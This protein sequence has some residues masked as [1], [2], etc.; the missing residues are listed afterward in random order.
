MC[1]PVTMTALAISAATTAGSSFMQNKAAEQRSNAQLQ[2]QRGFQQDLDQQRNAAAAQ[3]QNN[4]QTVQQPQMQQTQQEAAS[5]REQVLAPSYDQR[6]LLP[7]QG[8]ASAAVRT[9]VVQDQ[10]RAIE[11][12]KGRA[13]SQA[14]LEAFG[15]AELRR[16]IALKQ[17]ADKIGMYGSFATGGL[18]NL[19]ADLNAAQFAGS[20][21]DSMAGLIQ[22]LGTVGTLAAGPA[23]DK[24]GAAGKQ[25]GALDWTKQRVANIPQGP[26]Q[27]MG[28]AGLKGAQ[29][30]Y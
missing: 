29:Y 23:F 12:N 27:G 20:K 1:D 9:A 6:T 7:G 14:L 24:F 22:G 19:Q 17:N 18:D 2:A 13:K 26:R 4:L 30:I 11:A 28:A 10:N 15:D 3:F 21:A 25:T 5:S 16:D 8:D